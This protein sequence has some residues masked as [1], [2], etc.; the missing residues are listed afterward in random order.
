MPARVESRTSTS[1]WIW[2]RGTASAG[3]PYTTA[4][5]PTRMILPGADDFIVKDGD[6]TQAPQ[7]DCDLQRAVLE[8][9]F[10][11]RARGIAHVDQLQIP[12]DTIDNKRNGE[13]HAVVFRKIRSRESIQGIRKDRHA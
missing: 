1:A 2:V 4:C 11:G 8:R 5:S 12:E 9:N 13:H 7:Q 6:H 10:I 3:R